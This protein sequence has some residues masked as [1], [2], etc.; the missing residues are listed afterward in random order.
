MASQL[1][2]RLATGD[3]ASKWGVF[4]L[5]AAL[6]VHP[7]HALWVAAISCVVTVTI[8][9]AEPVERHACP[10]PYVRR[11]HSSLHVQTSMQCMP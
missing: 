5:L 8:H 4:S 2:T 1:P 11:Y 7:M 9:T 6:S 3:L 10:D